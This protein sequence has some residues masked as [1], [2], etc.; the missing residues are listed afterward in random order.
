MFLPPFGSPFHFLAVAPRHV[1]G[2]AEL[3]AGMFCPGRLPVVGQRI[4]GAVGLTQPADN[5]EAAIRKATQRTA[6]PKPP[7]P[8]PP[9]PSARY[10]SCQMIFDLAVTGTHDHRVSFLTR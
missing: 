3:E 2:F 7:P 10:E 8:S 5:L 1:H 6:A 4:R 9:P